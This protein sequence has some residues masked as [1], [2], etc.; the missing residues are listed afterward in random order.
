MEGL[1]NVFRPNG[2]SWAEFE[3]EEASLY[4]TTVLS[5][6]HRKILTSNFEQ[7]EADQDRQ[8]AAQEAAADEGIPD[9]CAPIE[10]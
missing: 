2:F 5:K 6:Q 3:Q 1:V 8:R 7:L 10:E 9:R 4:F